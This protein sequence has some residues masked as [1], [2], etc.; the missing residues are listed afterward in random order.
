MLDRVRASTVSSPRRREAEEVVERLRRAGHE[1]LFAGGS[2]R[3]LLLG[4]EPQDYDVATSARAEEVEDLFPRTVGVGAQFGVIKVLGRAGD[5][6]VATYRSDGAYLD[7]RRPSEVSFSDARGDAERRDFT[8][9]GMFYD[10]A[11]G[12]VIDYVGGRADLAAGCIRAIGDPDARFGEDRLRLLRAVRFA[13]R[14]GFEIDAATWRSVQSH[15]ETIRDIAWERIGDEV[16]K[17]LREGS[18]RR[19]F[20]LLAESG[21][22]EVVLPEVAAMRGVEQSP[23]HHPEGDVFVHTLLCLEKIRAD[24]HDIALALAVLLH[25]VAKPRTA[26]RRNDGRITFYGHCEQGAEMA[27]EICRRLRQSTATSDRVAWLV[28]NHLR[29]VEAPKMRTATLKR[30]L[31]EPWIDSLLE[32]VRIDASSGSGD[33][34]SWQFC[35][36]RLS[37]FAEEEVRP[38]PLL[39]GRDLIEL[40]YVPGPGFKSLLDEALDAQLE[41]EFSDAAAA[42]EWV[43]AHHP[44]PE[45]AGS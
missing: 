12:D 41:G 7:H 39:R 15:A 5:V 32:L 42:R 2:V 29:H 16:V 6:E 8:I 9:N 24:R 22:L 25:D 33:L 17:I 34:S 35:V 38:D 11:T 19:G 30:F 43:L 4:R 44:P 26:E 20:A 3:D 36:D 13:A 40:G 28:G 31:G 18:A 23:D 10:P 45:G 27:R 37:S 1:A 21:L 14:F